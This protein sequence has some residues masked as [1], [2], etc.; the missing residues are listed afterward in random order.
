MKRIL[1]CVLLLAC[2]GFTG[3]KKDKTLEKE[4][5]PETT[6]TISETENFPETETKSKSKT[7]TSDSGK[8]TTTTGTETTTKISLDTEMISPE[9][10]IDEEER[11]AFEAIQPTE[12]LV[13]YRDPVKDFD[14]DGYA[15]LQIDGYTVKIPSSA[16]GVNIHEHFYETTNLSET[17]VSFL[18]N[19]VENISGN[20]FHAEQLNSSEKLI[21]QNDS[22]YAEMDK[23]G[24]FYMQNN[25]LQNDSPWTPEQEKQISLVSSTDGQGAYSIQNRTF[26]LNGQTVIL[27]ELS[28]FLREK[29]QSVMK[30]ENDS[31]SEYYELMKSPQKIEE[32]QLEDGRTGYLFTF[33]LHTSV[34]DFEVDSRKKS[35]YENEDR[36]VKGQ[37][38]QVFMLN[39]DSIDY[40]YLPPIFTRT[41][42]TQRTLSGTYCT[43]TE[44]CQKISENLP[45]EGT[46]TVEN[47]QICYETVFL[48]DENHQFQGMACVPMWHINLISPDGEKIFAD[49]NLDTKELYFSYE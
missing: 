31:F 41:P 27:Q 20:A 19:T 14:K 18:K 5:S 12:E 22:I 43:L 25:T 15:N 13:Y 30:A 23:F 47:I 36:A 26:S 4:T 33:S 16:N 24:N 45:Q 7:E 37:Y 44:A 40:L 29:I 39:P 28:E 21:Y 3:C 48:N 9:T 49:V 42:D 6:E 8:T 32:I 38:V 1:L 35:R 17:D 46:F 11:K 34:T 2:V 10:E